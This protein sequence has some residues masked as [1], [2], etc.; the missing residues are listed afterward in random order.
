MSM[1]RCSKC[2]RRL[3]GIWKKGEDG[4][5]ICPVCKTENQFS[6][7]DPEIEQEIESNRLRQ[8]RQQQRV[9]KTRQGNK[10]AETGAK[11]KAFLKALGAIAVLIAG[12]A[13]VIALGV[14]L[15]ISMLHLYDQDT[16]G[17]AIALIV[18]GTITLAEQLIVGYI[19]VDTLCEALNI[20]EKAFLIVNGIKKVLTFILG[21]FCLGVLW[22]MLCYVVL[23]YDTFNMSFL[24]YT[25]F[26]V[27]IGYNIAMVSGL[28]LQRDPFSMHVGGVAFCVIRI[29]LCIIPMIAIVGSFIEFTACFDQMEC[30][31]CDNCLGCGCDSYCAPSHIT[32]WGGYDF[33]IDSTNH[34]N[35]I[36]GFD[37]FAAI[38][39]LSTGEIVMTVVGLGLTGGWS[40]LHR[41][42]YMTADIPFGY[43]LVGDGVGFI[44]G[45][46][47]ALFGVLLISSVALGLIGLVLMGL[48]TAVC[49]FVNCVFLCDDACF[50][51]DCMQNPLGWNFLYALG[52][53]ILGAIIGIANYLDIRE[54]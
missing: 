35:S 50:T 32:C 43:R 39:K 11:I 9:P 22:Y 45:I 52:F 16:L 25:I 51:L 26:S 1:N 13:L 36:V 12:P 4:S 23:G 14:I 5:Y 30:G 27:G 21:T 8:L 41:T 15:T 3:D 19:K 34:T 31:Y 40:A 18:L 44:V 7:V 10:A 24:H 47:Y 49:Y 29:A 17:L 46:L 28:Y 33:F 48:A 2:G 53:I 20:P 6:E 54:K 37:F 38:K 42:K